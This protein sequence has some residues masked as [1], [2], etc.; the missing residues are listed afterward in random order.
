MS[1]QWMVRVEGKEYGPVDEDD[2]RDWKSE[3]RLIRTNEVCRVGDDRW[4]PAGELPEIFADE[5]PA[6]PV[7]APDLIVRRRTWR[8]IFRE[9]IRIYRGGFWR[10]MLF[11]L[12]T[13]VPMFVLQWY[14]PR[15][16]F[17][18][19]TSGAVEAI[20]AVTVPPICWLMFALV[21]LVWPISTAGFQ[22]VADDVL[23]G[24]R[25]TVA[26]QFAAAVNRF[27]RMLSTGLV[28]YGSYFFWF[29]VPLT[30][31]VALL[32]SGITALSLM[33]YLL[34][35]AFMVYMNARLF[36]NFL[37]WEQTAAFEDKGALLALRESKELARCAPGAPRLDRPL[38][39]GALIASLWVLLLLVLLVGVQ[40]PITLIRLSS[41]ENPEQAMALLQ[42]LAQAKTPDPLMITSD[43]VSA[44]V[45]LIL[46][47]LLAAAFVVLYYDAKARRSADR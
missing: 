43:V 47:P 6:P 5:E 1:E 4:F 10:F 15:V 30:A 7:E 26:E 34:I 16:P 28:A 2:L 39:R 29:F 38:F 32:A 44:L 14:F 36:I 9:T 13:A 40:F 46:R 3:G 45:N 21:V 41:V 11:G 25:R 31:M 18:D 8:E 19:L 33:L 37:F 22:Y 27:G 12:L 35:G 17:P 24:R 20:P 23:R 42:S